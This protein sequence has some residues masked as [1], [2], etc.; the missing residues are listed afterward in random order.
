M[1]DTSIATAIDMKFGIL[2][3]S[4]NVESGGRQLHKQRD[5]DN[6]GVEV[7]DSTL[8]QYSKDCYC[9]NRKT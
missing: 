6:E 2:P 4:C 3:D 5:R 9:T 8:E 7:S 1:V